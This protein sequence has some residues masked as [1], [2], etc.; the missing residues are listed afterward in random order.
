MSMNKARKKKKLTGFKKW[1][2]DSSRIDSMGKAGSAVYSLLDHLGLKE[3]V[4]E[5]QA[6]LKWEEIVGKEI[7]SVTEAKSI[8]NGLLKVKVG[9]AAWRQELIYLKEDIRCKINQTIGSNI[10]SDISFL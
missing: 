8:K 1:E 6:V 3:R 10:V 7:A 5:Q 2:K 4:F 9:S